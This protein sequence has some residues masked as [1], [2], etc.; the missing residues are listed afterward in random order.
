MIEESWLKVIEEEW[1]AGAA[2][3]VRM[4]EEMVMMI[5]RMTETTAVAPCIC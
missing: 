3:Y 5:I 4:K 2:T 1:M